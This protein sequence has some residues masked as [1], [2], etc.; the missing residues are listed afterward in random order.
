MAHDQDEAVPPSYGTCSQ[1]D[2]VNS[3]RSADVLPADY[4]QDDFAAYRASS[5]TVSSPISPAQ[6]P[7]LSSPVPS[8]TRSD[9]CLRPTRPK[10]TPFLSPEQR[11]SS[12]CCYR[13][14]RETNAS[15]STAGGSTSSTVE[16]P[17]R[18]AVPS[19]TL[20]KL[21]V[22][23]H[24]VILDHIFGY[25]VSATSCNNLLKTQA[26]QSLG[27]AMRHSRRREHTRLALVSRTWRILIQQRLYRHVK[28]K[29]TIGEVEDAMIH[30]T[31]SQHLRDH[32]RHIEIWFPVFK[33]TYGQVSLSRSLPLP[34]VTTE[35]GLTNAMYILPSD[36][37]SLDE[38]FDFIR[39]VLP[40]ALVLTLEGGD[41]RKSPQVSYFRH[42]SKEKQ[43]GLPLVQSVRTLITRGQ[44]NL[45]RSDSDYETFMAA[46][47]NVM[48]WQGSFSRPKSKSYMSISTYLCTLPVT[49]RHL[50]LCLEG[51]YKRELSMPTF[52]FKALHSTHICSTLAMALPSLE[53]FSYTGRLCHCFFDAAARRAHTPCM[54]L[55]SIDVTVKN[56]CREVSL[57]HDSG[58]GVYDMGFIDA[59]EK[60]VL[61]AI[62]S[63]EMFPNVKYLRIRFVDI[64]SAFP[65]LNPYFIL[66]DQQCTGV[67]SDD[68]VAQMSRVRPDAFFPE[69][70]N[71]FGDIYYNTQEGRIVVAP[72]ITQPRLA[73]LK[74]SNYRTLQ[75]PRI[76][77][78]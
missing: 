58:S 73:S 8:V 33:P 69:L 21:P 36:N 71:S 41:R 25:R 4:K 53:T 44:W 3:A 15:A 78:Q 30:F 63:L 40:Q 45:I 16:L 6:P 29:A 11:S 39:Q 14:L 18:P 61:S 5:R 67:W 55:T 13:G 56:C 27:T 32:V 35:G 19:A 50:S 28:L 76:T 59:F 77:I 52:Y 49:L 38:V 60:L 2:G 43:Q 22:E 37:C 26:A 1:C 65:A 24:E 12:V 62:C 17:L 51:D 66:S 46:F 68:I 7:M 23:V 75:L 54:K 31:A 48:D 74:L 42:N 64:E 10:S 20:A 47:P 70:S 34:V 72:E 9:D 57:L